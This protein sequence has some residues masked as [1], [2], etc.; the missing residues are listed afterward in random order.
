M[1]YWVLADGLTQELFVIAADV[2][3]PYVVGADVTIRLAPTGVAVV[4]QG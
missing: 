1:E 2:D 3:A 4:R